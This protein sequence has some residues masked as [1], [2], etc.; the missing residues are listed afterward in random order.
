MAPGIKIS[1]NGT[2]LVTISSDGLNILTVR[3]TGDRISPE[4]ASLDVS[5]G[6]YGGE[7][8]T[9]L[10]WVPNCVLVPGDEIAVSLLEDATTSCLGKTIDE[11]F[12]DDK[13][14]FGPWQPIEKLFQDIAQRPHLRERFSFVVTPP[15]GQSIHSETLSNDHSFGFSVTWVWL[16]PEQARVSLSSNTIEGIAK[17]EGGSTHA[18]FRLH[19]G[20]RVEF[21]VTD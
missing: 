2:E 14:P 18:E 13:E 5:G 15:S 9:H 3:A 8:H 1:L 16:H 19:C 20:Q 11:L 6:Q 17:R 4:F 7:D 12:P 10:I 21:R